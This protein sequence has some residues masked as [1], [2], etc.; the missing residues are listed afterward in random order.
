MV[1]IQFQFWYCLFKKNGIDNLEL[2]FALKKINPQI[3]L[4]YTSN[5]LAQKYL[6][7]YNP[8]WNINY[9]E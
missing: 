7:H 2:M 3:N 1:S 6:F 9:S 4:P 5:L 8:T